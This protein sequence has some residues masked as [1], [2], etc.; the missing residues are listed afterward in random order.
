MPRRTKL[1]DV[2]EATYVA[3]LK[4]AGARVVRD[5]TTICEPPQENYND[6]SGDLVWP[7]SVVATASLVTHWPGICEDPRPVDERLT[8]WWRTNTRIHPD[9]LEEFKTGK[10]A[11]PVGQA[12]IVYP[13]HFEEWED[14]TLVGLYR[15]EL[16][17]RV[18]VSIGNQLI[19]E[20]GYAHYCLGKPILVR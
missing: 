3:F 16:T 6:F 14:S 15:S 2:D 9:W 12:V 7:Y 18:M 20:P 17:A 11:I 5:V 10:R 8:P 13:V 4:W 19:R 1:T